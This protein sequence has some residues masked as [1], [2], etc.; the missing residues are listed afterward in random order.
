MKLDVVSLFLAVTLSA[1][2]AGCGTPPRVAAGA[3]GVVGVWNGEA[4]YCVDM[5]EYGIEPIR[6]AVAATFHEDRTVSFSFS[7]VFQ[8][9]PGQEEGAMGSDSHGI[10]RPLGDGA[11]EIL[12]SDMIYKKDLAVA[13]FPASPSS[14][15]RNTAVF[16]I[17]PDG[18]ASW[19]GESAF[20]DPFDLGFTGP[21]AG[22]CGYD[23][24]FERLL[25]PGDPTG[26]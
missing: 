1:L 3:S 26:S 24:T 13:G 19:T 12:H 14:R 5:E 16:T 22:T 21:S 15:D 23:G 6:S 20:H 8:A 25:W 4:W 2:S 7:G 10:W 17:H 9:L 18:T 11:F